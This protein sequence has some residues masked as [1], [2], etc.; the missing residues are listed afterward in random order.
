MAPLSDSDRLRAAWRALAGDGESEGW[1]TIPI[2]LDAPCRLLAG[3]HFPGNEE[4]VLIGFRSIRIPPDSHLPHARGFRVTRIG[5]E[6]L[7]G[8]HVWLSLWREPTGSIELF[9]MM[10]GDVV[11]MLEACSTSGEGGLF[12]RF[13]GRI[14]AWQDFMER[15]RDGL[16]GP[17]AEVGLYGELVVIKALLGAG[18]PA[19]PAMNAWQG[20]L[21]GLQDF[22]VGT[23]AI[24]VKTTV[25]VNSFPATIV[26]LE[27]LDESLKQPLF[28]AAVRLSLGNSGKPLPEFI[29]ELRDLLRDEPTALGVFENRLVQAGFLDALA[30]RYTRRFA[31]AG[32][33]ILPVDGKFP[34]LT[35]CNVDAVIR[36]ARYELDL[37]LVSVAGIELSRALEQLGAI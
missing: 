32:T 10:A 6:V 36:R 2:E 9:A 7:G 26:S 18:I 13:L 25:A 24:E 11:A 17:E 22:I 23:G 8:T 30:D 29:A 14:G 20:P 3:R 34:R 31:L 19:T 4:A 15:G 33:T 27:Q 35:R 37:D 16:L 1:R 12:Q 21:D 28:L 5:R